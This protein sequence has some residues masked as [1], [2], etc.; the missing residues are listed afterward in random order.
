MTGVII[1]DWSEKIM[2]SFAFVVACAVVPVLLVACARAPGG[3]VRGGEAD[4]SG[5]WIGGFEAGKDWIYL[6]AHFRRNETETM[7]TFDLPLEFLMGA[8]LDAVSAKPG[9]VHFE[10]PRSTG[11]WVFDG[12]VDAAG[13]SGVVRHDA[14]KSPFRLH[15]NS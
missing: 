1:L 2:R 10:I 5:D 12:H 8:K 6:Q 7:G 13:V 15:R 14:A 4:I 11:R 3:A 9:S